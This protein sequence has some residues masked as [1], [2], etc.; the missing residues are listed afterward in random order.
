MSEQE[1]GQL[2]RRVERL[3]REVRGWRTIVGVV[4]GVLLLAAASPSPTVAD[5]I[6]AREFVVA[7]KTGKPHGRFGM[8]MNGAELAFDD[9]PTNLTLRDTEQ[10]ISRHPRAQFTMG[11]LFLEKISLI[12]GSKDSFVRSGSNLNNPHLTIY[13]KSG[14]QRLVLAVD[15]EGPSVSLWDESGSRQHAVLG[16][17][18]LETV[19]TGAVEQRSPSSLVVFG[20][21]GQVIWKVP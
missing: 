4:A 7:D 17:T 3:E 16:Y 19:Q 8:M 13:G 9:D 5:R 6:V 21:D 20:K 12:T 2:R 10:V 11:G 18:P 15:K 14:F 1:L